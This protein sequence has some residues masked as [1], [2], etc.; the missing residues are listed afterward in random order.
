[1][2]AIHDPS[3][4]RHHPI[5]LIHYDLLPQ[6]GLGVEEPYIRYFTKTSHIKSGC[7]AA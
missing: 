7:K 4:P 3:L 2:T 5:N 1:M 6:K